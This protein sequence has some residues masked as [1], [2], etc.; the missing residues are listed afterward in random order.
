MAFQKEQQKIVLIALVAVLTA[1]IIY[2]SMVDDKP[3]TAPLAYTRGAV[4][5]SPVRQGLSA[6]GA[7]ADP[8]T[9]L[10][11]RRGE[12]YPGVARDIFRMENPAP[13]PKP[14]ATTAPAF[15]TPPPAVVKTPAEIAAET[16]RAEAEAVRADLL[17]F[18]FLGYLTDKVSTLFLSK[19]GELFIVKSGDNILKSY[20][21]KDAKKNYVILYDTITQVEVRLELPGGDLAQQA[22]AQEQPQALKG[23]PMPKP[24]PMTNP[25]QTNDSVNK[26]FRRPLRFN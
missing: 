26:V 12:K 18:Q 1:L 8:L 14:M 2:R 25:T 5:D 17:K 9:V 21:I 24:M 22:P 11:E 23:M 7:G 10:L 6:R 15:M 20:K 3:K 16:A 13:K 19:D 4:A